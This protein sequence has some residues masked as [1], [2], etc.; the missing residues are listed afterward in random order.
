MVSTG[1]FSSIRSPRV[2]ASRERNL[3]GAAD[4]ALGL[5]SAF[6]LGKQ[7]GRHPADGHVLQQA[8]Q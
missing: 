8:Q 4:E 7:L 5:G 1:E 3:R 2:A 6:G